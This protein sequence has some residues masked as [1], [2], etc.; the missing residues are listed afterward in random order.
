MLTV[1][2]PV[3][4]SFYIFAPKVKFVAG[5]MKMERNKEGNCW[6]SGVVFEGVP[7]PPTL[8]LSLSAIG[9]IVELSGVTAS[10][11]CPTVV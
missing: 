7:P 3:R 11:Q 8:S 6:A 2:Q 9:K 4:I 1:H 5:G 10:E